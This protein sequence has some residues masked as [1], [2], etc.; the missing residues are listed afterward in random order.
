MIWNSCMYLEQRWSSPT[1]SQWPDLCPENNQDNI[2]KTLLP[3]DLF[4]STFTLSKEEPADD[5]EWT[6]LLDHLFLNTFDLDLYTQIVASTNQDCVVSDALTALQTNGTPLMKSALSDW[7][8]KDG[9]VFYKNK[10]YVP[11]DIGLQWEVV[12][13]YHDLPPMGHP[14]HLKTLELL[15]CD[16][17][18]PGMHT[19]VKNFVDGCAACQQAKI[20]QHLTDPPLMPIKGSTT[21][22]PFAQISYDFIT[23][24]LVTDGFDSHGRGRPWAFK[25][26]N[27]MPLSQSHQ[28]HRNCGTP[29]LECVP[30]IWPAG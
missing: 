27:F 8:H 14:G 23:D 20:N 30:K 28:C 4:I 19:F 15:W 22:W 26:G 7:W 3:D 16:Y 24:L 25:G 12:K 10:C 6:L 29:H 21:G 1:L 5:T 11:D 9:I 17:W 2:D 18:W 13:W